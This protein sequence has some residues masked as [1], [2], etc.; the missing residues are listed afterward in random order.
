MS[1]MLKDISSQNYQAIIELE[2]AEH[3]KQLVA[4]NVYSLAQANYEKGMTPRAI[5][6]DD[7]P[8]GFIMYIS[9]YFENTPNKYSIF[10]F[11]ID[12]HYQSKG[13]GKQALE[14]CIQEISSIPDAEAIEL[15][16]P[17]SNTIASHFY[18][19]FGFIKTGL[20]DE[21]GEYVFELQL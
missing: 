15:S 20:I 7:T 12:K 2:L 14:Q 5:Y 3:Q 19:K 21:D 6:A 9:L 13:I 11:M 4:P 10:R 1:I 16:V 18:Q 17:P 8:V